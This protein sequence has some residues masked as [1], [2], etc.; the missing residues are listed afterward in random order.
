MNDR[1][2]DDKR[3]IWQG[4]IACKSNNRK[5]RNAIHKVVEN[6]QNHYIGH[7]LEITGPLMINAFFDETHTSDLKFTTRNGLSVI[8]IRT[9]TILSS[10]AEYRRE[11][12]KPSY[13]SLYDRCDLFNYPR[14]NALETTDLVQLSTLKESRLA[15]G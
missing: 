4:L 10:Y 12:G 3:G 6:V 7:A 1:A 14:L 11:Y 9:R 8:V 15:S 13:N 2:I 5:L